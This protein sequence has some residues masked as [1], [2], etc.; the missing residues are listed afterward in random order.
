M[1]YFKQR[2]AFANNA[3]SKPRSESVHLYMA[4]CH[5]Q[6]MNEVQRYKGVRFGRVM[7]AGIVDNVVGKKME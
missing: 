4:N 1:W 3:V 5:V 7:N 6:E 2:V